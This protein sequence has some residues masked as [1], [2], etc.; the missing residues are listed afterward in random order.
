MTGGPDIE[1]GFYGQTPK[2]ELDEPSHARDLFEFGLLDAA[3]CSGI[4]VLGICRGAQIIN[5]HAGGTLHQHLPDHACFDQPV[6]ELSHTVDLVDGSVLRSMYGA[7]LQ[8]NS[9]H[10]QA[11]DAV[12]AQ[13][14]VTARSEDGTVEGVEHESLPWMGIQWHPEMLDRRDQDP[15]FLWLVE[16]AAAKL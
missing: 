7:S 3:T 1:P 5:V 8:V 14:R 2:T 12:G 13:L 11:V 10:H 16:A 4:P 15:V 9:L 6:N